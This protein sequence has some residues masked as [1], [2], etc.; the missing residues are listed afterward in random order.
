MGAV[1]S[2]LDSILNVLSS[3]L[4]R[5]SIHIRSKMNSA[6]C[7]GGSICGCD[8][9]LDIGSTNDII[10]KVDKEYIKEINKEGKKREDGQIFVDY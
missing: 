1:V 6:C 2:C 8:N 10:K 9:D 3:I 7:R 5:L 4:K